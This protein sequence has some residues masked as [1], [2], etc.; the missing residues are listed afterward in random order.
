MIAATLL[1]AFHGAY[2]PIGVYM[3]A[4]ACVTLTA[5]WLATETAEREESPAA[6]LA[7]HAKP[8]EPTQYVASLSNAI[9]ER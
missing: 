4:L 1:S 7:E 6:P 8:A 3:I 2:W 5:V 9:A